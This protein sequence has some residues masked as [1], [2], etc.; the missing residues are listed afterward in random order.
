MMA[1]EEN[2]EEKERK[3]RLK[4]KVL[5]EI[6]NSEESYITQL[7]MLLNVSF[8]YFCHSNLTS[9]CCCSQGF[10]PTDS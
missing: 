1:S 3:L 9:T 7:D 2:L 5:D 4:N 8:T 10:C 6:I